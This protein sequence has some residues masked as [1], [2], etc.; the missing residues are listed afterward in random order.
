MRIWHG[1][2]RNEGATGDAAFMAT[3]VRFYTE[4]ELQRRNGMQRHQSPVTAYQMTGLVC[5][6]PNTGTMSIIQ[7][8]GNGTV[9]VLAA[10]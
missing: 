7:V 3:N 9:S 2:Q 8:D 10:T 6:S 1:V 4:G 5:F